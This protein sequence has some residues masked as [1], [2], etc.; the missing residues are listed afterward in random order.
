MNITNSLII[1]AAIMLS[2]FLVF[3]TTTTTPPTMNVFA[4][5]YE[6]QR[7]H[8]YYTSGQEEYYPTVR[9]GYD[10]PEYPDYIPRE[11]YGDGY[12]DHYESGFYEELGTFGIPYN[13]EEK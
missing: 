12:Y 7:S 6:E 8:D 1:L 2:S 3:S 10:S 11:S 4:S 9:D 5:Q 13:I